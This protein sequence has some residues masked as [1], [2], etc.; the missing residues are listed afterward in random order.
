[1]ERRVVTSVTTPVVWL[2]LMTAVVVATGV[3]VPPE[4]VELVEVLEPLPVLVVS[5]I[6]T[7]GTGVADVDE[8]VVGVD[9]VGDVLTTVVGVVE[10]LVGFLLPV[11]LAAL[12]SVVSVDRL[13]VVDVELLGTAD[14]ELNNN[15]SSP[16]SF[17]K[18][19]VATPHAACD[20][21]AMPTAEESNHLAVG[22]L[23]PHRSAIFFLYFTL[24]CL[25]PQICLFL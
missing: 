7:L 18:S 8:L 16:K 25:I 10:L 20:S 21:Y 14:V 9:V 12:L 4:V 15:K 23:H 6:S 2:L 24:R 22:T 19:R 13:A 3:D 17:G 1:M 11:V 5:R